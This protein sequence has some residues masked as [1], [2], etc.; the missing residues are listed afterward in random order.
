MEKKSIL[1]VDDDS[2]IQ[3]HYKNILENN[4]FHIDCV[5]YGKEA[6]EKVTDNRY[7]LVIL[8]IMLP[9]IRGDKLALKLRSI[10]PDINIIFIT[11][12][13]YMD[14]CVSALDIGI[15]EI[16]IKPITTNELLT[17]IKRNIPYLELNMRDS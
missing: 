10:D 9:D 11:G 17:A 13:S 1:L 15:S 8:D 5:S 7:D 6:I 4:Y 2:D 3:F 12:F 14:Y 16:L